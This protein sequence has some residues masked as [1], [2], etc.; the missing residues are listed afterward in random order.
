MK[1]SI[2]VPFDFSEGATQALI[3]AADLQRTVRSDT[4]IRLVHVVSSYVMA[5][6]MSPAEV[7]LPTSD[8]MAKVE[9]S[10]VETASRVG[11]NVTPDVI[12]RP[13]SIGE[14]IVARG[15]ELHTDLIVMGTHGRTGV[16]RVVLGSV[17]EHVVRHASCPVVTVRT[18]RPSQSR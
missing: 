15:E 10:L 4:P 16:K 9:S 3:W 11:A 1:T 14:A 13:Q 18:Y 6:P 12:L 17:A 8:D 5:D 2:L 7:F